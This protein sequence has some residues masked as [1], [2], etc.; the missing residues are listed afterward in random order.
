[1][2]VHTYSVVIIIHVLEKYVHLKQS[3]WL[4]VD[5]YCGAVHRGY[6]GQLLEKLPGTD[7]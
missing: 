6:N 1:M 5:L 3:W 7:S 2:Y 4:V